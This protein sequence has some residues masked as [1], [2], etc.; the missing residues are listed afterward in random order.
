MGAALKSKKK[1]KKEKKLRFQEI[2]L[3]HRLQSYE[4]QKKSKSLG[5]PTVAQQKGI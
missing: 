5:V 2:R 3:T 1:K 4:S